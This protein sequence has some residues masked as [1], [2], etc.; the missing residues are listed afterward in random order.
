MK[1]FHGFKLAI[2]SIDKEARLTCLGALNIVN[3]RGRVC[4]TFIT[5]VI[6]FIINY[7]LFVL[8]VIVCKNFNNSN[9]LWLNKSLVLTTCLR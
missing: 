2:N 9:N 6:L 4:D 1:L 3:V 8:E 7:F 5:N